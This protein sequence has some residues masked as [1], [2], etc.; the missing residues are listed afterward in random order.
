[1]IL[2]DFGFAA[3]F[4]IILTVYLQDPIMMGGYGFTPAQNAECKLLLDTSKHVGVLTPR[5]SSSVS[6]SGSLLLNCTDIS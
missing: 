1:M 6:G 4:N 2:I 5:Q 3:F